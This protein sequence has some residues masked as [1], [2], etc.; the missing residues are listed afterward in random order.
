M[1]AVAGHG[2]VRLV[3]GELEAVVSTGAAPGVELLT[4]QTSHQAGL[5]GLEVGHFVQMSLPR[6]VLLGGLDVDLLVDLVPVVYVGHHHPGEQG[7]LLQLQPAA[8]G[9]HH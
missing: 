2:V 1:G 7:R 5:A 4:A 6:R 8:G 9:R 3:A